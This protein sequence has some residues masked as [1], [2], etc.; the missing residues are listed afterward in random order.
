MIINAAPLHDI[1][2]ITV[3]DTIL[4]KP[5][6]LTEEEF[7]SMQKHCVE[8][9]RI[10][11]STLTGI[12]ESDY[13]EIAKNV[14]V[15]HHEKWNGQ[16]YPYGLKG[17]EIPI[18]ARMMAIVDV[19]DALS[20]KRVYKEAFSLEETFMIMEESKGSHFDPELIDIFFEAKDEIIKCFNSNVNSGAF[21]R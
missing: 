11:D 2:K 21:F 4:N 18:C 20:S 14:S 9:G 15:Y 16:G 19:F 10:I 7:K 3:S 1:G 13:L 5:G 6:K 17:E 8:G 12:E